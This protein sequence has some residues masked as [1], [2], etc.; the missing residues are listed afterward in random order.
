MPRLLIILII[1]VLQFSTRLLIAQQTD[2]SNHRIVRR[3][4]KETD[5]ELTIHDPKKDFATLKVFD[6]KGNLLSEENYKDY[7]SRIKQGF[8]KT[9]YQ[10]GQPYFVADYKNDLLHG[11]VRVYS[12]IG[13]LRRRELYKHG[14][15]KS[16]TCYDTLG[17]EVPFY[18]F[19]STA[20]YPGGDLAL[21]AFLRKKLKDIKVGSN[22][23][24]VTA[25]VIVQADSTV[26]I[27][28]SMNQSVVSLQT[29]QSL[30]T[31]MPK[32]NPAS[33]DRQPYTSVYSLSIVFQNGT[34]YLERYAPTF[35]AINRPASPPTKMPNLAEMYPGRRRLN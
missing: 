14:Y 28:I 18:E 3:S 9:Y 19:A 22:G 6:K 13:T 26:L 7:H 20:Q 2:D 8:S 12:E 33:V 27:P 21:Q 35:I 10:N 25:E 4:L 15:R 31:Q 17:R 16:A 34:L 32:W 23:Q 11:E 24:F 5:E 1:S 29:W 30:A